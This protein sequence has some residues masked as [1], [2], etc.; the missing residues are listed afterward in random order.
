MHQQSEHPAGLTCSTYKW[1]GCE[2]EKSKVQPHGASPSDDNFKPVNV[3]NEHKYGKATFFEVNGEDIYVQWDQNL[4]A[5]PFCEL[6]MVE[7]HR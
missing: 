2:T 7:G 3:E 5:V 4:P 1:H 6:C